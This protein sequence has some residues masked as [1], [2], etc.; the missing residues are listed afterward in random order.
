M[1]EPS[2]LTTEDRH[3]L[4]CVVAG[5]AELSRILDDLVV[6]T[7]SKPAPARLE[8]VSVLA[9]ARS[10]AEFTSLLGYSF[11]IECQEAEVVADGDQLRHVIRNLVV[12]ACRH[13][14]SPVMLRGRCAEGDYVFQV[15]DCGEGIP[16]GLDSVRPQGP[17]AGAQGIRV[18]R[19]LLESMNTTLAYRRL[20]GETH[21]IFTLPLVA[22]AT[23]PV[24]GESPNRQKGKRDAHPA[25]PAE[26]RPE[27]VSARRHHHHPQ[28]RPPACRV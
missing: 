15:V 7:R 10:V 24:G 16:G 18:A 13:G 14:A 8:P 9:A 21:L 22:P 12:N 26:R 27:D 2:S 19:L 5:S 25:S 4:A 1:I 20:A 11:G 17:L 3:H 23:N 6:A 28:L